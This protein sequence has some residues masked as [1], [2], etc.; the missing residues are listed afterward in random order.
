[1]AGWN[2]FLNNLKLLHS[3]AEPVNGLGNI[4]CKLIQVIVQCCGMDRGLAQPILVFTL[5][6]NFSPFGMLIFCID[7]DGRGTI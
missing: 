5:S 4:F 6:A 7:G 1:M 2:M 3:F